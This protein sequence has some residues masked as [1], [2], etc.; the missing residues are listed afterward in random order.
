MSGRP[1]QNGSNGGRSSS[2]G[3]R[4]G[5]HSNSGE[6]APRAV[7]PRQFGAMEIPTVHHGYAELAPMRFEQ[8]KFQVS[9]FQ[10]MG[11]RRTQ[12]DRYLIVPRLPVEPDARDGDAPP[13]VFGIFDGTVGDFASDNVKDI[14]IPTLLEL[15]SWRKFREQSTFSASLMTKAFTDMFQASDKTLLQRCSRAQQH[16]STSTG[17]VMMVLGDKIVVGHL[18]DSRM[19]LGREDGDRLVGEQATIDHKPDTDSERK[20]IEESGGLVERLVNHNNKPFIRGGDFMMRKALGE[21]PMQLQYSRAF[22]AKD[23]KIFGMGTCPDVSIFQKDRKVRCAILASDGL[24]DVIDAQQAVDIVKLSTGRGENPAAQLIRAALIE[25]SKR[26]AKA[27]NV[28][29]LV[30]QFD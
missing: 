21:Q 15:D 12:E 27:D 29:V 17:V 9:A 7:I 11:D 3:P 4:H 16:Y 24:W 22:G 14:V 18:G 30:V 26:K 1:S 23:L 5:R 10:H 2:G 20:R 28:T 6:A 25:Q 13:A 19:V 8:T